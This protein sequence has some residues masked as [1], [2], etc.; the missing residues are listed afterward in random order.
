[1][2]NEREIKMVEIGTKVVVNY[3]AG[4]PEEYGVVTAIKNDGVNDY[5]VVEDVCSTSW[6]M[7]AHLPVRQD[8]CSSHIKTGNPSNNVWVVDR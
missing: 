4:I 8:G 2:R 1:M 7:T 5:A 3:G 6:T